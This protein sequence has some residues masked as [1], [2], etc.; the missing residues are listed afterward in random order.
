MSQQ[1]QAESFHQGATQG[2]EE[3]RA[4][5]V[6]LYEK[7]DAGELS[8]EA[9]QAASVELDAKMVTVEEL[10]ERAKDLNTIDRGL[11]DLAALGAAPNYLRPMG[12]DGVSADGP[13]TPGAQFAANDSTVVSLQSLGLNSRQSSNVCRMAGTQAQNFRMLTGPRRESLNKLMR[14]NYG[15]DPHV[16]KDL[17][18]SNDPEMLAI[19]P[20]I[21][22]D[23]GIAQGH[24]FRNE[25][26]THL[27]DV[28][29]IRSRAR[30][31]AT[32]QQSVSF[33]TFES[34][35]PMLPLRTGKIA[36]GSVDVSIRDILGR[37]SF[38][39]KG[40]GRIVKVPEQFLRDETFDVMGM[41]GEEISKSAFDDEERQFLN[42]TGM[43]EPYGILNAPIG[44]V[45]HSGGAASADFEPEDIKTLPFE[46]RAIH[47]A[48]GTWMA[49]KRFYRKVSIM[50]DDSGATVGTGQFLFQP[51][52]AAGDPPTLAGYVAMESEFFP[53]HID[54]T[55]GETQ[56]PGDPIVLFGDWSEYWIVERL[57]FDL[58]ILGERYADTWEVGFRYEK[59]LDGA[60]VK[61]EP[62]AVLTR[63]A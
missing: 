21:D 39:P 55:N 26:I 46:I 49:N 60:P 10:F 7:R 44:T 1:A 14:E 32:N 2:F 6:S 53:D 62:W 52:L 47:R 31:F 28:L 17:L 18:A 40:K 4:E 51:G 34:T 58:R 3:I 36:A 12:G 13:P 24:E 30:V 57:S 35:V 56:D 11:A 33:P 16:L 5:R 41:V 9:A 59:M 54:A 43:D 38:T 61:I 19:T 29:H 25:F 23:G 42:G 15:R 22:S 48:N 27:R 37:T 50:R 63:T 20:F 8:P 45:A